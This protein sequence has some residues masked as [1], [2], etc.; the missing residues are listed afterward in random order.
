MGA[1]Y[2][3]YVKSIVAYAPTFLGY[4]DLVL[5]TVIKLNSVFSFHKEDITIRFRIL[6][7]HQMPAGA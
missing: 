2:S 1:Q 4:N 3:I 7:L 6:L 5:G